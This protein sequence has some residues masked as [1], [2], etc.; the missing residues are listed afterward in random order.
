MMSSLPVRREAIWVDSL[1]RLGMIISSMNGNR[2]SAPSMVVVRQ[3]CGL[4]ANE[5]CEPTTASFSR[6]GP[7]P[8]KLSQLPGSAS[9]TSRG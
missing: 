1:G 8:T 4:R 9:T 3:Y 2:Y 5:M 6:N 7:V